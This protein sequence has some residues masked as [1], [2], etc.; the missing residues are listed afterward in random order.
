M[1]PRPAPISTPLELD[2][3]IRTL[4]RN[5][6]LTG[7][8]LRKFLLLTEGY[9]RI[10]H[11]P[12][13]WLLT[14]FRPWTVLYP[15]LV[16]HPDIIFLDPA[17]WRDAI[18]LLQ[19]LR[20]QNW[21]SM[22]DGR[23]DA[24]DA[25]LERAALSHACVGA[26]DDLHAVYTAQF[27]DWPPLG[28]A[29]RN[30]L[31]GGGS[32][33]RAM[34]RA[35]RD[36]C[37]AHA[38]IALVDA[39]L[40][41]WDA[42]L[43]RR[44]TVSIA[45]LEE[46]VHRTDPLASVVGGILG[47]E[48]RRSRGALEITVENALDDS[49]ADLLQ[50]LAVAQHV[51]IG[52]IRNRLGAD[53]QPVHSF[54]VVHAATIGGKSLA[55]SS[56]VGMVCLNSQEYN[57]RVQWR[58]PPD[59]LCIGSLSADGSVAPSPDDILLRKIRL[60]FFSPV[61]RVVIHTQQSLRALEEY[62]RLLAAYPLRHLEIVG[63]T[64]LEEIFEREGI[65]E[66]RV[67]TPLE[68]VRRYARTHAGPLVASAM[69]LLAAI[70]AWS[71]WNAW[72]DHPNLERVH[73]ITVGT[74]SIVYNPKDSLAWCMRDGRHVVPP[75]VPFGDLELGDGMSR[76]LWIWNFGIRD[77]ALRLEI[78]GENAEDWYINWNP[79]DVVIESVDTLRMSVMFAPRTVGARK[80]AAL[81]LRDDWG[82]EQFRVTL[83]GA[84]GA[85]KPAG[86][87]VRLDG[88]DDMLSFGVNATVFDAP[89][90]TFECWV[91]P[92]DTLTG[93]IMHNGLNLADEPAM[94]NMALSLVP[95][96]RIQYFIGARPVVVALPAHLAQQ[97]GRWMHIALAY[98]QSRGLTALH[99]NGEL[100]H[101][102]R[103]RVFLEGRR[104]PHVTFGAWN[105]T[106]NISSHFH[107]DIDDVRFWHAFRTPAQIR[108]TMHRAV[109]ADIPDLAGL[110]IFDTDSDGGTFSATGWSENARSLG[111]PSL[112]RSDIPQYRP[113]PPPVL[114]ARGDAGIVLS[115]TT[116][117]AC[118]R[119]PLPR[120]GDATWAI[121]FRGVP[122]D[123]VEYFTIMRLGAPLMVFPTV[124][125]YMRTAHPAPVM[126]DEWNVFVFRSRA[127]GGYDM[128]LN[129]VTVGEGSETME[130]LDRLHRFEG[131]QLGFVDDRNNQFGPKYY[132]LKRRA[133]SR[134]R[135][136][137]WLGVWSRVLG[138]DEIRALQADAD[139]PRRSLVAEW[140]FAD[141]PDAMGN[142]A[143][144][145]GGLLMHLRRFPAW[146][147]PPV[148]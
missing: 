106:Q 10:R 80:R 93:F 95:G 49:A 135:A 66:Q 99:V 42:F 65:V 34:F 92:L 108:A 52:F 5:L 44:N 145:V 130:S 2:G 117:M 24:L 127:S 125:S 71:I 64:C 132:P 21:L 29:A 136:Y 79:G 110:W 102:R 11:L 97:P 23:S 120:H 134:P 30:R 69:L 101:L 85:P 32:N 94:L 68:R 45:M 129:G 103:E 19:F 41:R 51:A 84:S 142:V 139:L 15:Q 100:V 77:L 75:V 63:V 54:R 56:A 22:T 3:F 111:R 144:R 78:E 57:G 8:P 67:R 104:T 118:V 89:E 20:Q 48:I 113:G 128:F 60:A 112:V 35:W 12:S 58:I 87:A 46:E 90:G 119:N 62:R 4:E 86:Y 114:D 109:P 28:E 26:L 82:N 39:A 73:G 83:T 124:V 137:D 61:R 72:Y 98:S 14:Y 81:V 115:P 53:L 9:G 27:P 25:A 126:R 36:E 1:D 33:L 105:D 7:S 91:R 122:S 123:T 70:T 6:Q 76:N 43:A 74:S 31:L 133:L 40:R 37:A 138:D 140:Q 96:G 143:D 16:Q 18:A 146:D 50:Q 147:V 116:W 131:L 141:P 59:V 17:V 148:R 88:V 13:S 47:L 107:G 121:R 38:R 55:L